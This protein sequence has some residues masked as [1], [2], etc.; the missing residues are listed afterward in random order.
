MSAERHPFARRSTWKP[1]ESDI[2]TR[3]ARVK[4]P[5]KRAIAFIEAECLVPK[6]RGTGTRY[7][8]RPWQKRI[9]KAALAKGVL[10]FFLSG[11]RGL[12]KSGLAAAL[13]TWALF[14]RPGAEILCAAT[15]M[16]RAREVYGRVV[17]IIEANPRLAE[18]CQVYRNA[19]E[20]WVELPSRG[21]SIRPIPAEEKYIVGY[22]PT[23]V[24]V[25][26]VGYVSS[27]TYETMQTSLGKTDAS[28]LFAM[29]TPGVGIVGTDEQPNVM[30]AMRERANG[31]TP[32][33]GLVFLEFAA[34][35]TDDP[36][37]VRTW[38][39]ANP[40]VG[41]LVDPKAVAQDYATMPAH[42]FGQMRLGLWTQHESAWMPA[43]A[44]DAL[45]V[46]PGPIALG[47]LVALG[48]DGSVSGDCT[49]LVAYDISTGRIAVLGVWERDPS[50]KGWQ[51]PR[52]EVVAA[53]DRAFVDYTVLALYADPWHWRTE[54]QELSRRFG[55]R[56][57][58][59][60]TAAPSR[61]G[62]ATDAFLTAVAKREVITDGN[63]TL[64][65]HVLSAVAR[66]TS[67]GDVIQK[68]ARNP[69]KI[70]L[71]VAAILAYEA[72]RLAP[73]PSRFGS[74]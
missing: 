62:P 69:Q 59:W 67:A 34:R 53:I 73:P 47:S 61:M 15:S 46:V 3:Y 64:R 74:W 13:A 28:L 16:G 58:E 36:S 54:L 52:A 10:T 12:G 11:P 23:L 43:D 2:F 21:A 44:W 40:A 19:A 38:K 66:H 20:P 37:D 56:V 31:E 8:L 55:D 35:T 72:G 22:S 48:F 49:A 25:D 7:R 6:G 30:W 41:D 24:L 68:D 9:I 17:G 42:R 33:E 57:L 51:V 4:D 39:R 26:E 32:P 50:V 63:A 5:A 1:V 14:D 70:D 45:E 65:T 27:A 60:N 29:G 18:Q 71:A